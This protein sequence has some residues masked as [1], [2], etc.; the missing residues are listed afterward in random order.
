MTLK[1]KTNIKGRRR[2]STKRWWVNIEI[3]VY[4]PS[5]GQSRAVVLSHAL[6]IISLPTH[7][8]TLC[9][10]SFS[11]WHDSAFF[12]LLYLAFFPRLALPFP[13]PLSPSFSLCIFFLLRLSSATPLPPPHPTCP[14]PLVLK[15]S[16][17]VVFWSNREIICGSENKGKSLLWE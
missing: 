3:W 14:C 1:G 8:D 12:C 4:R 16:K 15:P 13:C 6:L 2:I 10:Q 17:G 5:E 11:D 7:T 9:P